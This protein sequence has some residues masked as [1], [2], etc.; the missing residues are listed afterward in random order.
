[1]T[2]ISDK[3]AQLGGATGFLGAPLTPETPAAN[4]GL[5]QEFQNGTIFFHESTGAFEVH[6]LIRARF[7]AMGAEMSM[8]GYP[9]TD[10]S[11]TSDGIGRYNHFQNGSIY[12]TPNTDAHEV[13]GPARARWAALRWERGLL[14]YPIAAPY[15]E[16]RN[17]DWY[18][19]TLFQHGK[20]EVNL[21]THQ[22]YVEKFPSVSSPNYSI[23]IVAYRVSNDDGTRSC[24]ITAN[25]VQRWVDEANRVYAAAGV[26]FTFD[27][28]LRDVH[29][30]QINNLTGEEVTWW[31]STRDRLN[32]MAAQMRSV[33]V[34]FRGIVARSY[35]D[36]RYDFVAM[37]SFDPNALWLLAHELGHHF[38]LVHTHFRTFTTVR[39]AEDYV[40]SGGSIEEFDGDRFWIDDTPPDPSIASLQS[41]TSVDAITLGSRAFSLAR[42]NIMSY[43]EHGG[44]GE[45]SHSQIDRV[46]EIVQ[47]RRSRYL[48]VTVIEPV[49]CTALINQIAGL[50]RR[51]DELIEERD[52]ATNPIL[53]RRYSQAIAHLTNEILILTLRARQ[54]GCL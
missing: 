24:N 10:E 1:M 33:V 43:W 6:G 9:M 31:Q 25:E 22:V 3:H 40:L 34:I 52:D 12:W 20:I 13:Y 17:R 47:E 2:A 50:Q 54:L 45:L 19:V 38:G 48:N 4:G 46:R 41:P 39:E 53:R 28:V 15:G 16:I 21:A 27:G 36:W 26:Q 49:D 42:K 11:S 23:P 18:H 44:T 37:T 29:D 14:G 8:L 35:S 5:K 30:T 51:L 32:L 7:E